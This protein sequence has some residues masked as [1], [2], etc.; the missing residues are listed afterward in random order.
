MGW[1]KVLSF[2]II[3]FNHS[4]HTSWYT[5]WSFAYSQWSLQQSWPPRTQWPR[6]LSLVHSGKFRTKLYFCFYDVESGREGCYW[7]EPHLF[8]GLSCLS[9]SRSLKSGQYVHECFNDNIV[10]TW[11]CTVC[12]RFLSNNI[13]Y[14]FGECG[15][16]VLFLLLCI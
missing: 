11:R 13:L 3:G 7:S 2:E 15:T 14:P 5:P 1:C 16:F 8:F 4:I 10:S 12:N 6:R 9:T